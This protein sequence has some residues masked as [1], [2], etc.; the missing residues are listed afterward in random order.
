MSEMILREMAEG[1]AQVND[2]SWG[3]YAFSRDILR[4]KI[5]EAEKKRMIEL[6]ICCGYEMADKVMSSLGTWDP[7][8]LAEKLK[9]KVE[10]ADRGQIADRVLFALFTPPDQIQIMKEPIE[11]A[12]ES[13]LPE[14][15]L[16]MDQ[17]KSLILGHEIFHYLEEEE[18]G[19]YT[20][21]EKV[22]LWR[23]LGYKSESTVRALSEI[24]GMYFSKKI[25]GFLYSPFA[26][27]ILLYYNYNS[28]EALKMYREVLS[29]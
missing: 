4:D 3:M 6:A 1:L 9:L 28:N 19:I 18:E 8:E 26:L 22:V 5:S 10:Y 15:L 14:G 21:R 23:L 7:W 25:N 13:G 20:R 17:I 16:T 12:A 24:A 2:L 27:D 29:Y 11:L